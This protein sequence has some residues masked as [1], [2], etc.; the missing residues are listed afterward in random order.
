[1]KLPQPWATADNYSSGPDVGTPTKVDPTSTANGFVR[2]TAA[3]AQHVNFNLHPLAESTRRTFTTACLALRELACDDQ[4]DLSAGLA[5][6]QVSASVP[7]VLTKAS[8][9]GSLRLM[10]LAADQGGA[11]AQ[12]SGAV[13]QA[14][15]INSTIVVVGAGGTQ[16]SRTTNNG[17]GWSAGGATGILT[18]IVSLAEN[19]TQFAAV[20]SAG[21]SAHSTDGITWL[22][23]GGGDDVSDVLSPPGV[24]SVAGIVGVFVAVGPDGSGDTAFARSTDHGVTWVA[25]SGTVPNAAAQTDA[26][27]VTGDTEFYHAGYRASTTV[28]IAASADGNTWT[29]RATLTSA[30]TVTGVKIMKCERT[31]LLVVAMQHSTN[32]EVRAST[33]GGLS[34][35]EAEY[36]QGVVLAGLAVAGGR[37]FVSKGVKLFASDG[38]GEE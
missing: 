22:N 21:E 5:A 30:L 38:V 28:D 9:S 10:G 37:L 31:D 15:R 14:A 1:M 29:T 17:T 6:A 36:L 7:I 12:V 25:A 35:S 27:W 13:K 26:G 33:D 34:W 3:A 16:V 4:D 11:L 24:T 8:T 32:V 20:S 19:G 18:E 2:G 23:P